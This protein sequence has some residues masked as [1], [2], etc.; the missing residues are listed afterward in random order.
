[1]E[2]NVYFAGNYPVNLNLPIY[3]NNCIYGEQVFIK[4]WTLRQEVKAKTQI[5]LTIGQF[6]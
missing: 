1:M 4:F 3:N 6:L 5:N 2:N